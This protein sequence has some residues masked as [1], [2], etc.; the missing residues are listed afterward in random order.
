M[1]ELDELLETDAE[2]GDATEVFDETAEIE[3][4]THLLEI[5]NDREL[6]QFIGRLIGRAT[7]S[8][9][10]FARTDTGR[11]IGGIL[12]G[13]AKKALPFLGRAIGGYV[14][15]PAGA[16]TGGGVAAAAGRIFGLGRGG[17]GAEDQE[18]EAARRFVRFGGSAVRHA[19]RASRRMRPR[20]AARAGARRAARRF[21][22]GLLRPVAPG[23]GAAAPDSAVESAAPGGA[24]ADSPAP[25]PAPPAN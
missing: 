5:T 10:Q 25:S 20:A 21:A 4:A 9:G 17:L 1:H 6:D 13:A 11:A 3:L 2:T 23:A 7:Q 18:F 19:A 12:K 8:I 16:R 14:A 15:G 22:P 24:P